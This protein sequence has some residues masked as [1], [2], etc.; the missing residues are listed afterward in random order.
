MTRMPFQ[1]LEQKTI[2][3]LDLLDSAFGG[4]MKHQSI[5]S[6]SDLM[7]LVDHYIKL[8]AGYFLKHKSQAV[9][10]FKKYEAPVE[11]V[12]S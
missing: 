8:T 9:D 2:T 6:S 1:D 4:P 3:L 10:C 12:Q 11:K 5:G 7:R